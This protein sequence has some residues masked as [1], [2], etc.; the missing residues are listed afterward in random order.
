VTL[1]EARDLGRSYA[2]QGRVVALRNAS[3]TIGPGEFVAVTGPSGAGK[4]TLASLLALLEAPT[5]GDCLIDGVPTAGLSDADRTRLRSNSFGFVF[6]AFHLIESRTAGANVELGLVYRG[7]GRQGRREAARAALAAV[8][9]SGMEDRGV[10]KLSG[11]ERQRVAIARAIAGLAPVIV[12]DE[13]TG[14]LDT[15]NSAAV[16]E[17]LSL[18]RRQGR[19]LIVVTHDAGIA[20]SADRHIRLLDGRIVEDAPAGPPSS[21]NVGTWSAPGNPSRLRLGDLLADAWQSIR[22]GG[23]RVISLVAA[24]ALA[25]GLGVATIGLSQTARYQVSDVFDAA[26]NRRV[27]LSVAGFDTA[28]AAGAK[29]RD[30]LLSTDALERLGGLAGVESVT[31]LVNH[32]EVPV[33]GRDGGQIVE[34]TLYGIAADHAPETVFGIERPSGA[35]ELFAAD[36]VVLGRGLAESLDVG[37]LVASPAVWVEGRPMRV[38]GV[39]TDVGYR[40][41]LL[42]AV[43]LDEPSALDLRPPSYASVELAVAPGAALQVGEQAAVAWNPTRPGG[44]IVQVPPDPATMRAPIEASVRSVLATLTGVALLLAMMALANTTSASVMQ[45][46][47]EFGIRRALGARRV[48]LAGLVVAEAIITGAMGGLIGTY[49]GAIGEFAATAARHWTPVLDP[50]VIAIGPPAGA[51]IGLLA[52]LLAMRA[53]TRVEPAAAIRG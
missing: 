18:L 26:A 29:E 24:V 12:A 46:T 45:R 9:L 53:A 33:S 21:A 14:N 35:D 13:P 1:I 20:E 48:H 16:M 42:N 52:G 11:G 25:C 47:G 23:N 19:T 6:Q 30:A 34:A 17:L 31:L 15:G 40:T 41:E 51:A 39:L 49:L 43:I 27:A 10:A 8:G 2:D 36:G 32:L 38:T 3:L 22:H 50:S 4:S 44:V 5:S 7:I 28:S 37:P